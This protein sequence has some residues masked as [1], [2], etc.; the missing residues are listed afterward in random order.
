MRADSTARFAN[1]VSRS[2]DGQ[3]EKSEVETEVGIILPP[4]DPP[5]IFCIG[6]NYLDHAKEVNKEPPS[7]PVVFLKATSCAI[8][9]M[10]HITIPEVCQTP[11][12]VDY[13]AELAVVIGRAALNVSREDAMDHVLGY[14][15]A[16]D[17]TARRWQGKKGGGQ[18][19]RG[20]S[21][22]SFAPLGPWVVPRAYVPDPHA[23][24]IR[25]IL[26]G[27]VVQDGHTKNMHFTIPEII[28]FLSQGTTLLPGTV[29]LTGTPAGVGYTK[30][31]PLFLKA[32]DMVEVE[33][34][35]V[36]K[37]SN[38]V[39]EARGPLTVGGPSL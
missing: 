30:D 2:D 23:L 20:K 1:I 21:F 17:V 24:R 5:A 39:V 31:P 36:G 8:G 4:V 7:R 6:L 15:C 16:N 19:A 9:H 38:P 27:K 26:N 11:P 29:I 3:L 28:E 18:W 14:T 12:E 13:E 35:G 32:G 10:N 37:L 34:E 25:T 22:D 33:I